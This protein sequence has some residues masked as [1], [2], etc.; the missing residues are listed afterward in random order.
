MSPI[1]VVLLLMAIDKEVNLHSCFFTYANEDIIE[2]L[3]QRPSFR[4]IAKVPAAVRV[5]GLA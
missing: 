3:Q 4:I 5:L 1:L 2:H